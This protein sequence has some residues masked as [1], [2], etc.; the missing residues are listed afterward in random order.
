MKN[1]LRT[2]SLHSEY[3][4]NEAIVNRF[5]GEYGI[6]KE[7]AKSYAIVSYDGSSLLDKQEYSFFKKTNL[8]L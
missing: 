1:K 3:K 5:T 6:I 4:V 7:I 2:D 8:P